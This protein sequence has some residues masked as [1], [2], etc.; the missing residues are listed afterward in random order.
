MN[1]TG[2]FVS[3]VVAGAVIIAGAFVAAGSLMAQRAAPAPAPMH[4][5][6]APTPAPTPTLTPTPTPPATASASASTK[7]PEPVVAVVATSTATDT[8]TTTVWPEL[9]K[10]PGPRPTPKALET[11][12]LKLKTAFDPCLKIPPKAPTGIP[13]MVHFELD[14]PSG[15][16]VLVE[17]SRPFKGTLAGACMMRA[18]LD[19]RVPPFDSARW[20]IDLKFGP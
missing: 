9:P 3:L 12:R 1:A 4:V 14:G 13:W 10:E 6:Q 15:Q 17:V 5:V 2:L 11:M 19:A 7:A 18:A 20:A 8:T 16:P